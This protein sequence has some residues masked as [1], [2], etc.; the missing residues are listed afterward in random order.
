[1]NWYRL[2]LILIRAGLVC[3]N[4]FS[5]HSFE[6]TTKIWSKMCLWLSI[7]VRQTVHLRFLSPQICCSFKSDSPLDSII[8]YLTSQADRNVSDHGIVFITSTSVYDNGYDVMNVADQS[9]PHMTHRI[10]K[11]AM[12]SQIVELRSAA[13][14]FDHSS[15]LSRVISI[16]RC[17]W[18]KGNVD[19]TSWNSTVAPTTQNWMVSIY[20]GLGWQMFG[21][22]AA[23]FDFTW[24]NRMN[25]KT[26]I[27]LSRDL[28]YLGLW[29]SETSSHQF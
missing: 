7:N 14:P 17:E 3:L 24:R 27:L 26:I 2:N 21:L 13:L 25:T 10:N 12:I 5:S 8:A 18:L 4:W 6:L 9:F 20:L 11:F 15:I 22:K 19:G 29:L 1:M 16:R 28:N 23:I